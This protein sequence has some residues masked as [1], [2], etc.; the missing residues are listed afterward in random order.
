MAPGHGP[1]TP[2]TEIQDVYYG[3]APKLYATLSPDPL[4]IDGKRDDISI[5]D[6]NCVALEK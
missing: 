6:V 1:I 5:E 2:D 3:H 4:K